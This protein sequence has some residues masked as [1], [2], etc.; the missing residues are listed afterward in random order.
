VEESG[1]EGILWL[2][3]RSERSKWNRAVRIGI[4]GPVQI[5]E[6]SSYL[7]M[8]RPP[9]PRGM[10]GTAVTAL[11]TG[12][13]RCGQEVSVYTLD[14]A[15]SHDLILSDGQLRLFIGKYRARARYRASDFFR[16]ERRAIARFVE[17]DEA[18]VVNAHWTYEFGLGALQARPDTLVTVRDW[19]PTILHHHRNIYRA[20]RLLM[21]R[22]CL[23]KGRFFTCASPYIQALLRKAGHEAWV[24]PNMA[25]SAPI[26]KRVH[27]GRPEDFTVLCVSNGFAGH[28]NVAALLRAFKLVRAE[29]PHVQLQLVG[30]E[31]DEGGIAHHWATRSGCDTGVC[32]LGPMSRD[33]VFAHMA[34]AS[35]LVHPSL[36]ESFGN[37]LV[38]AMMVGLP[39]V[40][41]AQSGAVPWV[42]DG[43]NAGVLVD[44]ADPRAIAKVIVAL[45]QD[46]TARD[47]VRLAGMQRAT[48]CFSEQAVVAQYLRA[49]EHV[50][51]R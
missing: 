46:S 4:A 47:A 7:Q 18:D 50:I 34:N 43:G 13:L 40:G 10:G 48:D 6:L 24:I 41:G 22:V 1:F 17:A 44:V 37:V 19:A 16:H 38:E 2:G 31:L 12:L 49:Y 27:R 51:K 14:P 28:K 45:A 11:V 30:H 25:P 21:N 39:V 29:I 36:E 3:R 23:S 35:L 32:F 8:K 15:V 5:E 33:C 26:F 42:L 20:I 9:L